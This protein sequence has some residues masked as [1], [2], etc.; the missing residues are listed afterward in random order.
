MSPK[1][2]L[3]ERF[4]DGS[5]LWRACLASLEGARLHVQHLALKS[6]NQFYAMH[7]GTGKTVL[8]QR[9]G[10]DIPGEM[11]GSLKWRKQSKAAAA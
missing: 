3:F 7:I 8:L 10:G 9:Q 4:P 2:D 1:Y 11:L 6:P 5:S